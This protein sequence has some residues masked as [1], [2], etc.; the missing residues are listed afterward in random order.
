MSIQNYI[1]RVLGVAMAP[2]AFVASAVRRD[3][4]F[5]PDG[6]LYR[7]EVKPDAQHGA[8][9]PL[10]K[11]L[12]GAALVRLSGAL[13]RWPQGRRR[14]DLLGV[15]LRVR[16]NDETT[17]RLLPGDQDLSFVT[18]TT[19]LRRPISTFATDAGDFL[20]NS[21][22]SIFP[23]LL[24]DLGRVYLR[25]VPLQ[26]A[27]AGADR[28]QRLALA[29]TKE[30]ATLRLELQAAALGD[31]W[32]SLATIDLREHLEVDEDAFE[33]HPGTSAMGLVPDGLMQSARPE[34][35]AASEAGRRLTER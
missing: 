8:L 34:I 15:A 31:D 5:H 7:A 2:L 18:A 30:K 17:V 33:L 35:Y 22:H 25:L 6:V 27:P 26:P 11:R 21:Y 3:R 24:D 23:Y 28:N 20:D 12:G 14:P 16:G 1:G 32:H 13:W 29:V 9:K 4:I 19:V 10:A